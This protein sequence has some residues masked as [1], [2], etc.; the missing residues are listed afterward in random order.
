MSRKSGVLTYPEPL[1]PPRP[2]TGDLK[3]YLHNTSSFLTRP[4]QP[5]F[6]SFFSTTISVLTIGFINFIGDQKNEFSRRL[7]EERRIK[8]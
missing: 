8:L 6:P 1:G 7:T 4:I 2:L 3:L 5:I